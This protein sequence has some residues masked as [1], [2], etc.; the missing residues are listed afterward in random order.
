MAG[1]N[2]LI[3]PDKIELAWAA[4]LYDG[5][6]SSIYNNRKTMRLMVSQAASEYEDIPEVLYRFNK[7]I[8]DIGNIYI[9][10]GKTR[11]KPVFILTISKKK[12]VWRTLNLLWPYLSSV[13][14][15][16][17]ISVF[18][19]MIN[20]QT[21]SKKREYCRNGGHLMKE[22]RRYFSNGHSYCF[23]CEK[24]KNLKRTE[25]RR[26]KKHAIATTS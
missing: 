4:G 10:N 25:E 18:R 12:D 23:K 16:Q 7:A 21:I 1:S 3:T 6:G 19:K 13:K 9:S 8:G 20:Y 17:I 5:E 2:I 24:L 22:T 15:Q 26:K 14:K 11:K